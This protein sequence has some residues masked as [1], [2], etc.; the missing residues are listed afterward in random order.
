MRNDVAKMIFFALY[1]KKK[2]RSRW[3]ISR[4]A[5]AVGIPAK[6]AHSWIGN[7]TLRKTPS[8]GRLDGKSVSGPIEAGAYGTLR[9][10]IILR[11]VAGVFLHTQQRDTRY[12]DMTA[13]FTKDGDNYA[14]WV[15][16]EKLYET[17]EIAIAFSVCDSGAVMHKHGKPEYVRKWVSRVT[18]ALIAADETDLAMEYQVISSSAWPLEDLDKIVQIA[19]YIGRFLDKVKGKAIVKYAVYDNDRPASVVGIPALKGHGWIN[20]KFDTLK[21]AQKYANHWLGIYAPAEPLKVDEK[22]DYNSYGEIV[23]IKEELS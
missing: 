17:P 18:S 19:G 11:M 8:Y 21:E 23:V 14:Y 16:D 1:N 20:H 12:T 4:V 6:R 7:R 9:S 22:Y 5:A 13:H 10:G 2:G 15:D 3:S